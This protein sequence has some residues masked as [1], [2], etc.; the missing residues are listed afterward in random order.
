MAE[1]VKADELKHYVLKAGLK[2]SYIDNGEPFNVKG[3]GKSTIPLTATQ[4]DAFKDKL[5][6]EP[7]KEAVPFPRTFG[8]AFSDVDAANTHDAVASGE[9]V[10]GMSSGASAAAG[11]EQ[12]DAAAG[13]A[14]G[15]QKS[16]DDKPA[17][18]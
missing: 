3:D 1:E 4:A 8:S 18:K 9:P 10:E 7:L 5:D 6:G 13:N 16:T 12:T 15:A 14:E 11:S 17:K 2:H